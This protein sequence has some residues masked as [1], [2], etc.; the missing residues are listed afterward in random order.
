AL[1]RAIKRAKAAE[2]G[3][4]LV[5]IDLDTFK[6]VNDTLGT[7]TGDRLLLDVRQRLQS[8]M[9]STATLARF[10]NDQFAV[11]VESVR[12]LEDVVGLADSLRG[13]FHSPFTADAVSLVLGA[14]IGIA[15]Y[16]E[17]AGSAELLIQRADAATYH[18][19]L[20]GSGIE[21]YAA[22]NDPYAPRRLA[23]AADLRE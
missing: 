5:F 13:E 1:E 21:V 17:H 11:L 10:A 6:E 8:L 15:A 9:P 22:D 14:S 4:A 2:T 19:R 7:A 3:V 23:L 18:A 16:P 12:D 20:E